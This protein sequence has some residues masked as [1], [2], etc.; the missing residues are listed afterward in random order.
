MLDFFGQSLD[1]KLLYKY[2]NTLGSEIP[3]LRV[4]MV[5]KTQLKS[6]NYWIMALVGKMPALEV[7]KFH[8][9]STGSVSFGNDGWKY[10][11]KGMNYLA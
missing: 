4:N 2:I 9:R 10:L 11:S 6:N 5:K 3:V 7:L 8:N 1:F